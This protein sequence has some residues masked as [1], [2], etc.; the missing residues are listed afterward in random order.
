MLDSTKFFWLDP[1]EMAHRVA[2]GQIC[3]TTHVHARTCFAHGNTSVY[4][5]VKAALQLTIFA[6][7]AVAETIWGYHEIV[8]FEFHFSFSSTIFYRLLKNTH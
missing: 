3:D 1:T 8:P 6:A 7:L 2:L 5:S 4:I